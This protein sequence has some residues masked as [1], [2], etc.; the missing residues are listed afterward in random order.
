[1]QESSRARARASAFFEIPQSMKNYRIPLFLSL[2]GLIVRLFYYFLYA[3]DEVIG[4]DASIYVQLARHLADGNFSAGFD[5]FW[6]SFYPLLVASV[7]LF[8]NSLL[9]PTVIVSIITGSLAVPA[10][11]YLVKQSYS[12]R[13][14]LI[15]AV[16]AIFYPHLLTATFDY[17][18]ENIYLLLLIFA[19][20]TGWN[21]LT[22]NSTINFFVTGLL[23]GCAYL[24]R[25][26]AFGYLLF[27]APIV[28]L[29]NFTE[30]GLFARNS[31]KNVAVLLLGFAL[32]ATPYLI[33]I[34]SATGEWSISP[35][36]KAHIGGTN[37]SGLKFDKNN[38]PLENP[39]ARPT[40]GA[41]KL[42][43]K[44]LLFNGQAAYK[45][46]L[47]LFPPFLLIFVGLG[48]FRVKWNGSR[49]RREMY[50]LYFCALTILCYLLTIVEVR[51]FYVL[52]PILFG[53]TACGIV[54]MEDWLRQS[55]QHSSVGKLLANKYIFPAICLTFILFYTLPLN[56]F[57]RSSDS[58]W[59]FSQYELRNAGLWLK[60]NA[61]PEPIVMASEF[62]LA[63]YAEG[64]FVPL[65]S[66]NINEVLAEVA[67]KQVD[68]L[69]IDERNIKEIPQLSNLL[70]E[71]QN[72]PQLELVYQA[73][74]R[75][76]YKIVIYRVNK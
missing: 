23:I 35:K 37:F 36:F 33:Y 68:F 60:E 47:T 4:R 42:M 49:F 19:L 1:M 51:Y 25:P 66:D 29:K 57:F 73:N 15:A 13:E 9:L 50:L 10:T 55:L 27:F 16:I 28:F 8:T 32:L 52:L 17:G 67:E 3:K 44:A 14:A 20:I 38:N 53:W 12:R 7:G 75:E 18:T 45:L 56:N 48:L 71:P 21:G 70:N 74:E 69:V 30:Q 5:T 65:Y 62:R 54:E 22:K 6:T 46:F 64:K 41:G 39:Q 63:F 40:G 61:K 2:T 24:T 58:A 59:Q 26:E 31:F 11:Y 34:R 43:I 76:G 72:S